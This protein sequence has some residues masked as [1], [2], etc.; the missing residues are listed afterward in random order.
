[1]TII[2]W[3]AGDFTSEET[4]GLSVLSSITQGK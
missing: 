1:M 2:A 3:S 4:G